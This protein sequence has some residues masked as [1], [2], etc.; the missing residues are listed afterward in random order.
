MLENEARILEYFRHKYLW[1][2]FVVFCLCGGVIFL[3]CWFVEDFWLR[4]LLILGPLTIFYL[5]MRALREDLQ[6]RGENLILIK[7]GEIFPTLDFDFGRG[8]DE[9]VFDRQD[10]VSGY[11]IRECFNMMKTEHFILEEDWFYTPVSS[12]FL[13]I[14]STVFEGVVLAILVPGVSELKGEVKIVKGKVIF[15]GALAPFLK[16]LGADSK[17]AELIRFFGVNKVFVVGNDGWIYFWIKTKTRIFY[18]FSLV[19]SGSFGMFVKRIER[20][21]QIIE[22]IF[23]YA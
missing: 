21:K 18:Q 23:Y 12:K 17:I 9:K 7:K 1:Q 13:P 3:G 10:I 8:M 11:R 15:S 19:R 22:E 5:M 14:S 4:A 20:L 6:S 2:A 16:A